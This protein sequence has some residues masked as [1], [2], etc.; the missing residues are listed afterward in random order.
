MPSLFSSLLAD[1]TGGQWFRT[2]VRPMMG[3]VTDTRMLRPGQ[4]FVALKTAKRDGHDFLASA[5]LAGASGSIVGHIDTKLVVPQ[6]IV[7]DPLEALQTI[8]RKMRESF[9]GP[10]V[11]VTGS[12][13]RPR[14]RTCSPCC[15]AAITRSSRPRGISTI[16]SGCRSR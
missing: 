16:T 2:P 12:A 7:R 8:A 1:W 11:G 3:F 13:A 5:Q 4:V 9:P 14:R 10:V 15:L 6:L